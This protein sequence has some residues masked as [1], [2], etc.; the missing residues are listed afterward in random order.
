[1]KNMCFLPGGAG[2]MAVALMAVAVFSASGVRAQNARE[3]NREAR[4]RNLVDTLQSY[5]FSA[6]T[7]FPLGGHTRPLTLDYYSLEVSK[8]TLIANLPYYGRAFVAPADPSQAGV[9]FT[10]TKFTYNAKP[11]KKGGWDIA[12]S[13]TDASD[14][15]KMFLTISEDGY[16]TLQLT[17]VNREAI[18]YNGYIT[19]R[20]R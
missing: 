1:M 5:S 3:V 15:Q 8:D 11:G 17:F 14:V 4:I 20:H 13:A 10:S 19:R 18:S 16:A 7:V 6:Q 9:N 12:I 2:R